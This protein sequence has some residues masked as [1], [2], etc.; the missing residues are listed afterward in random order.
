MQATVND[1]L[2]ALRRRAYG[3]NADIQRDPSA[4]ERLRELEGAGR[5]LTQPA[6]DIG[7]PPEPEPVVEQ[8]APVEVLDDS[9]EPRQ[10]PAWLATL[11]RLAR[12]GAVRLA[13]LRRSTVL[14]L[15]AVAV[16]VSVLIV[17][18]VLVQR[19]QTDP[20][21]VGAEQVA[22]L[23]LDPS[24]ELPQ[25]FGLG[26]EDGGWQGFEEFHGLAALVT[27]NGRF[28]GSADADCLSIYSSKA[29]EEST[30]N[31]FSGALMNGCGAGGFPAMTQFR[32]DM[33]DLP[34]EV[35]AAFP[36]TVALQFVYD[37]KNHEVVVF[38][39]R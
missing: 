33:P 16:M 23:S 27:S 9:E 37:S 10:T 30:S 29:A 3:P 39:T 11:A 7:L 2:Q 13:H 21:Q 38:A 5:P 6:D 17:A 18:L 31:S 34:D 1:E 22:R 35:R 26:A 4:L 8:P 20:L 32:T 15:L 28:F 19:V 25:F 14:I 12:A 36:D 24:Y